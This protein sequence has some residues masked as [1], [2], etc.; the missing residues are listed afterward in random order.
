[1]IR[2]IQRILTRLRIIIRTQ[3]A[4][5]RRIDHLASRV[6]YL[7]YITSEYNNLQMRYSHLE[8]RVEA[9]ENGRI[10]TGWS[11]RLDGRFK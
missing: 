1:M 2:A 9:I 8:K 10:N 5:N 7:E 3:E 6:N 4:T 11:K